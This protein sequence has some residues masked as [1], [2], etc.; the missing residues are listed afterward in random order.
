MA[1][2]LLLDLDDTLLV[3]PVSSFIPAYFDL[4]SRYAERVIDPDLLLPELMRGTAAMQAN[5][6]TGPTNEEAFAAVFYPAVGHPEE[7]LKPV[8]EEFYAREFPKL[9]RLTQ[10]IPEARDLVEWAFGHSLQVVIATNPL[11][12]SMAI[13]ERLRWAGVPVSEFPYALVTSYEVMHAAKPNPAY[14][15]EIVDHL[16]RQPEECLMVGDDWEIDMVPAS[17][18]GIPAYWIA[19]PE[20]KPPSTEG[21]AVAQGTL[22]ELWAEVE[23]RGLPE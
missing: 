21:A 12:P 20:T 6:G 3:N 8:F 5:D 22:V 17:S 11:F 7:E 13:E 4:L 14:F 19:E 1:K 2:A 15:R 18:V 10:P 16:G 23:A 9:R